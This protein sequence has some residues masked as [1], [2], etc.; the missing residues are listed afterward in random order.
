MRTSCQGWELSGD[1]KE[2][3]TVKIRMIEHGLKVR[4][5]AALTGRS[6]VSISNL[7]CGNDPYWPG[8]AAVNAA[9]GETIFSNAN[10]PRRAPRKRIR[11][12]RP[13]RRRQS[14]AASRK[15]SLKRV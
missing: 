14:P 9:L 15:R 6:S 11:P 13:H 2:R 1:E 7:L 4:D 12:A 8:R 3:A 10:L 5:L